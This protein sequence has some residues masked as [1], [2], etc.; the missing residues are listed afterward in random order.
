MTSRPLFLGGIE[1]N[2]TS[3]LGHVFHFNAAINNALQLTTY[4]NGTPLAKPASFIKSKVDYM[5]QVDIPADS[6]Q[7]WSIESHVVP[8][9]YYFCPM[10]CPSTYTGDENALRN[11]QAYTT[12]CESLAG[13]V[14]RAV[15]NK[16]TDNA[17]WLHDGNN[18]S[19]YALCRQY[20]NSIGVRPV[21][22]LSDLITLLKAGT[23]SN[24]V[25]GYILTDITN[26]PESS[27]YATVASHV[28][29][30]IIVDIR[31]KATY[32]KMGLTML[33][34]ARQKTTADS[35]KDFKDKCNNKSLILMPTNTSDLRDFAI[36]NNLF[37]INI[38]NSN[39]NNWDL[40]KE[41][42]AWLKPCSPV[43]GW[44]D[45]DE[46]AFVEPVTESGNLMVPCN[47]F[48]NMNLTSLNYSKRQANMLA[49][50]INP[51]TISY[52]DN[53]PNKYVSYYLSDGD[54]VQWIFHIWYDGWF[55]NPQSVPMK[56]AFGI[57]S[58]N[59]SMI[60]PPVYKHIFDNQNPQNTLVENCG[61]G[62][63]YS[64]AFPSERVDSLAKKVT[65][66]MRQ[67]RMKILGLFNNDFASD[68]A[69]AAY[70][71]FIKA[72]NQL[73]AI[74]VVCY[75]PYNGGHG[76]V[77]WF[78]NSDGVDIPVIG[79]RY[80]LW[81]MGKNNSG[82]QGT[83]AYVASLMKNDQ[84]DFSLI[85]I[86]AWSN[87]T[88]I[89]TSNDLTAEAT[90][91]GS[92]SG[93]GAAALCQKHLPSNFK[94]VS[95]QEMV[96]RMRK[97]HESEPKPGIFTLKTPQAFSNLYALGTAGNGPANINVGYTYSDGS[98]SQENIS[99]LDWWN[100][101]SNHTMDGFYGLDRVTRTGSLTEDGNGAV[102]LQE[103]KLNPT[104]G[105]E[106]KTI[107]FSVNSLNATSTVCNIFGLSSG[108]ST[109]ELE[110]GAYNADV[111]AEALDSKGM[112]TGTTTSGIDIEGHVIYTD[113]LQF[114]EIV[115]TNTYGV[116]DDGAVTSNS[117]TTFQL[118]DYT[119]LNATRL[120]K[121]LSNSSIGD[122]STTTINFQQKVKASEL[123]VLAA[124]GNGPADVDMVYLYSDGTEQNAKE[125]GILNNIGGFGG[126][127]GT[128]GNTM[129]ILDWCNNNDYQVITTGRYYDSCADTNIA[130]FY[131]YVGY[132]NADK[133]LVGVRLTNQLSK[134]V[135]KALIVAFSAKGTVTD[136][137]N[138]IDAGRT[139]E[140]KLFNLAG[141]QVS[142]SYKG[143]VI[144][145]GQKII[146]K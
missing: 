111:I 93:A 129:N 20:L 34:D 118:A 121:D 99:V 28:Y 94:Y 22:P 15:E 66:N 29:S 79:V 19:S 142:K 41:V 92:V 72:N 81:N 109:V 122:M 132:P 40:Y 31:D 125:K 85:D 3:K 84:P 100:T 116:P 112:V 113:G 25:K 49:H 48:M 5:S 1:G 131:E 73:E 128:T 24:I 130:G 91:T 2:L 80:T 140:G 102:R 32:D 123:H 53:D 10:S 33:V 38:K 47:Y 98:T 27:S 62:Y 60:A 56:M 30:G 6:G 110:D 146:Q 82:G 136:G 44:G 105:K 141:Q 89:G 106:V 90:G 138:A 77:F 23:F 69:K 145:N 71:K 64:D 17:I 74:I 103:I 52:I 63:I 139:F 51:D 108:S 104:A 115:K 58:T 14:N 126:K 67:H 57:P 39:G 55:K 45:A 26:N 97:K 46:H 87:F 13:L 75:V 18:R 37:Y 144:K 137:I 96:W 8:K 9:A 124:A 35:W 68:K 127:V 65:A 4:I 61:G 59:L 95:L 36:A 117:G 76:N 143:I 42:L 133:E 88:D 16:E 43:Y 107:N 12:M 101:S 120:A 83:P 54:N 50:V 21:E 135:S 86:H 78:K 70:Q 11:G 134:D 7:Y 119:H 114:P